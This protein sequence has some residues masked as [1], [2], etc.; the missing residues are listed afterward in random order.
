MAGRGRTRTKTPESELNKEHDVNRDR[1]IHMYTCRVVGGAGREQ[2]R[3][4]A[5][6]VCFHT[7]CRVMLTPTE[8]LK[9]KQRGKRKRG[10]GG[11]EGGEKG[12]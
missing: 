10:G 1:L 7:I 4:T 11:G 2:R 5:G 12:A 6:V 3:V 8:S 9:V